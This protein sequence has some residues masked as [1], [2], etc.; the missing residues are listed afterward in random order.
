MNK[1]LI[2]VFIVSCI[3]IQ[4]FAQNE[5]LF[6]GGNFEYNSQSIGNTSPSQN[7]GLTTIN[8]SISPSVGYYLNKKVAIG[9]SV[10]YADLTYSAANGSSNS[11][12][13]FSIGGFVR[14][15]FININN[16]SFIVMG[17]IQYDN[18]NSNTGNSYL[19]TTSGSGNGYTIG[20]CPGLA[21]KAT[22]KITL[23]AFFGDLDYSYNTIVKTKTFNLLLVD[24]SLNLGFIVFL[25]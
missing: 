5:R 4:L 22:N 7:A 21:Y 18:Y 19:P 12:T 24:N 3:S 13:T 15:H 20:M 6:V 17:T 2:L 1:K 23:Q 16:F 10:G 11:S 14:Y 9:F 25:K 8:Y